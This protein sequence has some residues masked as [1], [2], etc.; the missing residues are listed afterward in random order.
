M[1]AGDQRCAKWKITFVRS[2]IVTYFHRCARD[3]ILSSVLALS[4]F[5]C[6]N[7]SV[8][9][10]VNMADWKWLQEDRLVLAR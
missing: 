8:T 10:F 4:S 7:R 9:Y 1:I 3:K 5:L 2:L 6:H